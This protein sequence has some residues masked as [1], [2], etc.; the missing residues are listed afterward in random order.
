S[1]DDFPTEG[2]TP[3]VVP[4]VYAANG[5][6]SGKLDCVGDPTGNKTGPIQQG[7]NNIIDCANNANHWDYTDNKVPPNYTPDNDP[8][9]RYV[10]VTAYGSLAGGGDFPVMTIVGFYITGWDGA[11]ASCNGVNEKAPRDYT[12]K[13]TSVWGH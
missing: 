8:R 10:F 4:H 13:G 7:M 2:V 6:H 11:P 5:V 12:G 9:Y 1:P 3:L